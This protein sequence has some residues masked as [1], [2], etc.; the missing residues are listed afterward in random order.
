MDWKKIGLH[1]SVY[2]TVITAVILGSWVL[3]ATDFMEFSFPA[4]RVLFFLPFSLLFAI[5]NVN[6]KYA[7]KSSLAIRTLIHFVL[8]AGGFYVFFYLPTR[9]EESTVEI[10]FAMA[11]I[12]I[13]AY[14]V[15]MGTFLFL[16]SR[17]IKIDRDNQKYTGLY[18]R[19]KNA[20]PEKKPAKGK[21]EDYKNV[22]KQK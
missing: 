11:V 3:T 19:K 16:R 2:F 13:A 10:A 8:T 12:I 7:E 1:T 6:F 14:W 22:Y 20:S 17:F 4:H 21:N 5:G 9:T 15:L 18:R